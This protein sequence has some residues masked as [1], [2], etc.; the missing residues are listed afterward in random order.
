MRVIYNGIDLETFRPTESDF[1]EK[2]GVGDRK[3]LLFV[4][5]V[6]EKRKGLDAVLRFAELPQEEYCIAVV[7][8]DDA[9][10]AQL[11]PGVISVHRTESARELA[12]IYT[13]A[14]LFVNPTLEENYPTVNMEALACGTP[15]LTYATGGAAEIPDETC[16]MAVPTGHIGELMESAKRIL[17]EKPFSR[18][19]CLKRAEGF[20]R[21][22][23]FRE[24]IRLYRE[25]VSKS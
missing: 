14:D 18:E 13:A 5:N 9:V 11:P 16:G 1:R 12:Q 17:R 10:D 15:V 20:D 23:R 3:L 4:A 25:L 2:H 7:G 6:W 8:T 22:A 21:N 24:Y 19:A